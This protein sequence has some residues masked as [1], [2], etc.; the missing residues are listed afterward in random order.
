MSITVGTIVLA[1]LDNINTVVERVMNSKTSAEAIQSG[2][3][4]E[5]KDE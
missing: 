3:G 5:A 4:G 1:N 2:E